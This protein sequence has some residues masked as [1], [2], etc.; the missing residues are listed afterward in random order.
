MV[1]SVDKYF[2]IWT[3]A[4]LANLDVVLLW[5]GLP[6]REAKYNWLELGLLRYGKSITG[7]PQ[8]VLLLRYIDPKYLK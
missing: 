1:K 7:V 6:H 3:R 4:V 2:S 8:Y 5:G